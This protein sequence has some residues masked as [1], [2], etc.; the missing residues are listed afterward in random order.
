[1]G[2]VN[3]VILTRNRPTNEMRASTLRPFDLF[4]NSFLFQIYVEVLLDV[5]PFQEYDK[6]LVCG[7]RLLVA[8]AVGRNFSLEIKYVF[9]VY[10]WFL[11]S[12]CLSKAQP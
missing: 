9:N 11:N 5:Y 6:L 3:G 12:Q 2:L 4:T 8:T 1:M 7:I 10:K